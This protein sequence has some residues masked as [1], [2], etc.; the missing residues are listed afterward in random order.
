M[1]LRVG[2]AEE[3]FGAL[4]SKFPVPARF[5]I[6]R[7]DFVNF[8]CCADIGEIELI[9]TDSDDRSYKTKSANN[10]NKTVTL[11]AHR[12]DSDPSKLAP[13]IVTYHR[14]DVVR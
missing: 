2:C 5:E 8:S 14:F 7:P 3:G 4:E 10:E 6:A 9:G 1:E 12:F 13:Y 11:C